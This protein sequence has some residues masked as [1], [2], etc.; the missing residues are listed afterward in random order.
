ML[1][2]SETEQAVDKQDLKP[3]TMEMLIAAVKAVAAMS[4]TKEQIDALKRMFPSIWGD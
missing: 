4:V 3:V 1:K 2:V